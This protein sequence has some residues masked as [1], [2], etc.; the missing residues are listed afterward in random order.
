MMLLNLVEPALGGHYIRQSTPF[1]FEIW[2]HTASTIKMF[3]HPMYIK[4]SFKTKPV[5]EKWGG[6]SKQVWHDER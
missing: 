1:A 3:S 2:T 4:L 5:S 6:R